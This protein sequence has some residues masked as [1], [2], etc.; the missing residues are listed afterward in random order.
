M[1]TVKLCE[2]FFTTHCS[3]VIQI[4]RHDTMHIVIAGFKNAHLDIDKGAVGCA[5]LSAIGVSAGTGTG[6]DTME[7]AHHS[8]VSEMQAL[9]RNRRCE[10]SM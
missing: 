4:H 6:V 9:P 5:L 2:V 3:Y 10:H 1:C 7:V 8:T